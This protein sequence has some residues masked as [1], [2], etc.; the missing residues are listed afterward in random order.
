[1]LYRFQPTSRELD[2]LASTTAASAGVTED[3]IE[4][5]LADKP[6]TIF[7]VSGRDGPPVLVLKKSVRGVRMADII[8]LDALGRLVLIECKRGTPP[9]TTLAQLIEYAASY[10]DNAGERLEH[11]WATGEGKD[12]DSA[13]LEHF[14]R[15]AEDDT[16]S[17]AD[18]GREHVP[19]VVAAGGDATFL[20]TAGYLRRRGVEVFLAEVGL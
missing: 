8:A 15:F 6:E 13:L 7:R 20:Q 1:M 16:Y 17:A 11:D 19:V 18:L 2:H 9:R 3:D 12:K 5:A 14:R 4:K 10:E